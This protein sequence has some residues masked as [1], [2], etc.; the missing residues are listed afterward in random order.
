MLTARIFASIFRTAFYA[1]FVMLLYRHPAHSPAV[2][3]AVTGFIL[4]DYL[5]WLVATVGQ[6][7]SYTL[8]GIWDAV[9]NLAAGIAIF[10]YCGVVMPTTT[11]GISMA[12]LTFFGV[13]ALKAV[14]YGIEYCV[15]D[16]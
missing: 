9:I 14:Y 1:G 16:L 10:N 4:A 12:G 3:G 2:S 5:T 8:K 13:G 7:S 15:S 11:D 6:L